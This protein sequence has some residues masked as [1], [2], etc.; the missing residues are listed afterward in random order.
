MIYSAHVIDAD[1]TEVGEH[2][3]SDTLRSAIQSKIDAAEQS[4]RNYEA[5]LL[6]YGL[7]GNACVGLR[8]RSSRLVIPRAHDCCTI[9]LGSKKRFRELFEDNPSTPFSSTGTATLTGLPTRSKT[10]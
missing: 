4:G 3:H 7:C 8:A 5:I 6:L 1:F 10:L 9:L 2:I